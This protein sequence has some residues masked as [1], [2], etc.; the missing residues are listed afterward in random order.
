MNKYI[1]HFNR[2]LGIITALLAILILG[3]C[4]MKMGATIPTSNYVYPNSN[5]VPLGQTFASFKKTSFFIPPGMQGGR[6][7]KDL[8]ADA[9]AKYPD[10]NLLIDYT[11]DTKFTSIMLFHTVKIEIRGT[12]A[13]MEIG[14]QDIGQGKD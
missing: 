10:A 6:I 7:V 13:K 12:A 1:N 8:A 9:T 5:V 14:K 11:V 3:G 4:S 2:N